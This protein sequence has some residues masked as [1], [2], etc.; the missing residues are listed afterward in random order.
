MNEFQTARTAPAY[1]PG[2]RLLAGKSVLITA[3]AGAGIGFAAAK[4]CAEEGCRALFISDIHERRLEQ[5]VDTLRAETGLQEIYGRLCNVSVEQDVRTLVADAEDR[6]QGV[7]VLINNAGLGGARRI[8]E[9]D[10]AEWSRVID[11]SLTGTFRMTRAILPHM[12]QRGR[13]V[14]V[15]N[16]SVLGWRAQAE[17]AHYA[18][19]KAGVMALTRCA[20][21]EAAPYGVRI[22][23][24]APSIA[25]H[26]F[27]KKSASADLLDQLAS[28]EAFGRAAE[29]W[30]VA[31]VMVFL[32]SDYASY[33]TGEVLSVSSQHA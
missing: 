12:Q 25:L 9:M 3:A 32:A 15:N 2:H 31:N 27:L 1:V 7:D 22:N 26:D 30:E 24:V 14:I 11:I 28:R 33:M 4:R 17:Q 6:L 21:L 5:A 16:A 18:A 8:V 19:A 20:A 29:V 23:A 10:D 13:G